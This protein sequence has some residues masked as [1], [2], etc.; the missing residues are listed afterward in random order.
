MKDAKGHGSDARNG[1]SPVLDIT[2]H[3]MR[4]LE[5]AHQTG[6]QGVGRAPLMTAIR[7]FLG[8]TSGSG[9]MPPEDVLY[10][11]MAKDLEAT[12]RLT[13]ELIAGDITPQLVVHLAHFLGFLAS[14]AVLDW[15][16]H[17][18]GWA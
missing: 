15:A 1:R 17:L 16:V 11:K 13:E 4:R 3:R 9:K 2:H 7:N 10:E 14:L 18:L 5:A 8:N 6:V 12:A